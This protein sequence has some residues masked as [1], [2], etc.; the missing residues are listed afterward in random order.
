[1]NSGHR[2][3]DHRDR[4]P[5]PQR[6]GQTVNY[7]VLKC[8][9]VLN[10]SSPQISNAHLQALLEVESGQRYWMTVDVKDTSEESV[11]YYLDNDYKHPITQA[12]LAANLPQGFTQL[13]SKPGGIALDYIREK[14]FDFGK[15]VS[16]KD[17]SEDQLDSLKQ[18]LTTILSNSLR[19]DDSRV[20]VFGSRFDDQVGGPPYGLRTGIHDIHMNQGSR[21][22]FAKSNGIYQDGALFVFFPTDQRWSAAFFRFDSQ[23]T[24]TDDSGN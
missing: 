7:N 4:F 5:R 6:A 8:R 21:G 22:E 12:L 1:M 19:F 16:L 10:R 17:E 15:M 18:Q 9:P 23:S 2:I 14:L 20:F 11:L 13:E 24:D 3:R